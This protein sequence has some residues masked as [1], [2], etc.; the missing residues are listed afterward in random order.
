MLSSSFTR[1]VHLGVPQIGLLGV[2]ICNISINYVLST[3][4][5]QLQR[6]LIPRVSDFGPAA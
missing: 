2:T 5:Q 3:E 6:I 4:T 1:N